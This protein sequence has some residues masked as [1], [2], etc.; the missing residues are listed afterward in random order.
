MLIKNGN[1]FN[2]DRGFERKDIVVKNGTIER[3]EDSVVDTRLYSIIEA[4][5]CYVVPGFIDIHTHGISG[6]DTMSVEGENLDRMSL[7]YAAQGVTSFLPTTIT[8]PLDK[9][10]GVLR[11]LKLA[12]EKG[13]RGAEIIGINLEGPFI[14]KLYKGAHCDENIVI[15]SIPLMEYFIEQSGGYIRLVTI[16]PELEGA[17]DLLVEFSQ[18]KIKFAAGHSALEYNNALQAFHNGITHITHLFNAMPGIH[19]R[20]PGLVGAALE[21]KGLTV[22]LIAD[23]VH[24]HPSIIKMVAKCKTDDKIVLVSDS[25]MAAALSDGEYE[26]GG[27]KIVVANGEARLEDG[28]L[29]GS[30]L[31]MIE[32]VK[33]MVKNVGICL[34]SAIKMATLAPAKVIGVEHK[35]GNILPGM[36]ADI[37]VVD[38]DLNIKKTIVGGRL[39]F[40]G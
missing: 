6:Y 22:E 24:I 31:T 26:L 5:D 15:P 25:T 27:R 16:A 37:V 4:S 7:A 12:I 11:K 32:A 38:K 1:V 14:N 18:S 30:V 28:T 10:S 3:V 35:K 36:D 29:A 20:K 19:H 39:V 34:E 8:S 17:M 13:T 23:G 2:P 9:I 33:Y 21:D 40:E